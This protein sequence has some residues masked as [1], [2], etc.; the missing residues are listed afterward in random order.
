M[1]WLDVIGIVIVCLIVFRL[2]FISEREQHEGRM[3]Q[4]DHR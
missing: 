2:V 3:K 1:G 4:N